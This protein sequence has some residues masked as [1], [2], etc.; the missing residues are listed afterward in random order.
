MM[1]AR[2]CQCNK[3]AVTLG[4]GVREESSE[5]E[6]VLED[7]EFRMPPLDLMMLVFEGERY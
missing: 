5:L 4:S 2:A 6:Y 1:L 7:E 3:G